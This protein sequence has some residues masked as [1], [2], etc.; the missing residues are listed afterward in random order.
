MASEKI[1]EEGRKT[2]CGHCKMAIKGG[3]AAWRR[4]ESHRSAA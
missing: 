1:I 4:E 2:T 3:E